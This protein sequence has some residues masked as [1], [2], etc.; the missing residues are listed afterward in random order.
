MTGVAVSLVLA[1]LFGLFFYTFNTPLGP[2]VGS[3]NA[4]YLTMGTALAGGYTPYTE[5]F[6]HKGPLVFVLQAIPQMIS[7]GYS[8]LAVFIQQV[9]FL[10]ACLRMID[11]LAKQ[12][13]VKYSVLAQL[14]YLVLIAGHIGGGNLTEEYSNLFTLLGLYIIMRV[15]DP[16]AAKRE[17][18][19][20]LCPALL[21]GVLT[22]L[23]M[24][25]RANNA[26]PLCGMIAALSISLL[27]Q[28]RFGT[29]GFCAL[30]MLAGCFAAALPI[31]LWLTWQNALPAAVYGAFTHNMMYAG[32]A[33]ASRLSMLFKSS[34]GLWAILMAVLTCSG[35]LIL[36]VYSKRLT[37]PFALAA[38]AAMGGFAAFVSHKYYQH[39][40]ILG[41]PLAATG[42]IQWIALF[43]R[44]ICC[45]R[46]R[47]AATALCA[48]MAILLVAGGL[49]ANDA[50]LLENETKDYFAQD[51]KDLYALVPEEDHDRFM[52][53]RVEPK[54][55]VY[56][57]ALPCMR[58][59]FLQEI[60]ADADPTVMDEIV[61]EFEND[62][63]KWLVIYY[64]REFGPPYD[65]RVA[66]IFERDYTFVDAKGQ[67]QL[68][69]LKEDGDA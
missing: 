52:A 7:G 58:F 34:Y 65:A 40:L 67:Y 3:D 47:R 28:R 21:L 12:Q 33:G 53:Y 56:T 27:V 55:Y 22:M 43:Q 37:L 50:R 29:L 31:V 49:K 8:T 54:W 36:L 45:G 10:F 48:L 18:R 26:L 2:S 30:G 41:A 66:E 23:C 32:T 24:L 13:R 16:D 14:I 59:Y 35:A 60:L 15:F 57:G 63:P 69:R 64:N 20:Y 51:A 17:D 39:Y 25:V 68:L 11:V 1:L 42:A 5:I 6:D 9:I 44:R 4:I 62:P 61:A 19:A 46:Q 38:G